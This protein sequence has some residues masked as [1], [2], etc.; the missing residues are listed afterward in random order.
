MTRRFSLL[1]LVAVVM[2]ALAGCKAISG[3]ANFAKCDFDFNSVNNV[4][5]CNIAVGQKQGLKDFNVT[6]ALK[7]ANAFA[8]KSFPLTLDI[9]VD[10]T[11]PNASTARLDGFEYILWIDDMKMTAGSM[12]KPISLTA[13]QKTVMPITLGVDLYEVL[14]SKGKDKLVSTACGLACTDKAK[15]RVK[16]SIKPYFSIGNTMMRY[17]GYITIGGNRLM[18]SSN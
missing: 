18:P 8:S 1:A 13:N 11:N 15:S 7:I 4:Q 12:S 9:N 14:S 17:P 5:L 6:D 3:I 10:V 16:L 2:I